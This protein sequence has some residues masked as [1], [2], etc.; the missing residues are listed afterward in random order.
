MKDETAQVWKGKWRIL[1]TRV[2]C[3]HL[4]RKRI[5]SRNDLLLFSPSFLLFFSVAAFFLSIL[6]S[7]YCK[8][9]KKRKK[10]LLLTPQPN[11]LF[12]SVQY[13]DTLFLINVT[14]ILSKFVL[15]HCLPYL[16][17]ISTRTVTNA[18]FVA[19]SLPR[20]LAFVKLKYLFPPLFMIISSSQP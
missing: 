11:I 16:R 9:A 3:H 15:S 5:F 18:L 1:N 6:L 13:W 20:M 4:S 7:N 12:F 14:Q 8:T 19:F 2:W 10:R 17:M